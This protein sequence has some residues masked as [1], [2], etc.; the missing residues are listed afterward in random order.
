MPPHGVRVNQAEV[1][2]VGPRSRP[3]S[4][5][6]QATRARCTSSAQRGRWRCTI[7]AGRCRRH[8]CCP[9]TNSWSWPAWAATQAVS[10]SKSRAWRVA[11]NVFRAVEVATAGIVQVR[12]RTLLMSS[13]SISFQQRGQLVAVHGDHGV[14]QADLHAPFAQQVNGLQRAVERPSRRRNLSCTAPMPSRLMPT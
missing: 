11:S 13:R 8:R 3:M 7:A 10:N 14:A 5:R 2:D 12:S 1:V 9:I 6:P 4:C